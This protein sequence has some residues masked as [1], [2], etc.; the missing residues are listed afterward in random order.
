MTESSFFNLGVKLASVS[1]GRDPKD[2]L[3]LSG[4]VSAVD[5]PKENNYGYIQ[6]LACRI[7]ADAFAEAGRKDELEYHLFEKLAS[8]S[9]WFPEMD[10]Y[11]DAAFRALGAVAMEYNSA[12]KEANCDAI[13]KQANNF[14][15]G[16]ISMTGK[17]T[18]DIVKAMAAAGALGGGVTGGLYWL[19]NRH[20]QE[21]EDEAEV[22]KAKI[23][24][25][26]RVSNEIK[27]QLGTSKLPP[28]TMAGKVEDIVQ[29]QNLF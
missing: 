17:S 4:F 21:D 25:Y 16:L 26:N 9:Q 22:I 15:P 6:K 2:M 3:A 8:S 11:S 29:N 5:N 19:L 13:V 28:A 18:P 20:S 10:A 24:Y 14:L 27:R 23:D 1:L 7:A 12:V